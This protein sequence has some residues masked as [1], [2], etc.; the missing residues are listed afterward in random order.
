[1]QLLSKLKA[2]SRLQKI[3][4]GGFIFFLLYTII[5]FLVLPPIVKS[6]LPQKLS[7]ALHRDTQI[8]GVKINPFTLSARLKGLVVMD[9]DGKPLTSFDELFVNLQLSSL[10]RRALVLKALHIDQP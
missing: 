10:F 9:K 2:M 3:L 4:L 6:V 5:G 8:L 1:M 7:L